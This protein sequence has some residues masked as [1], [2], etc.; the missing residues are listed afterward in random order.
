MKRILYCGYY[1]KNTKYNDLIRD[2]NRIKKEKDIPYRSLFLDM[3]LCTFKYKASFHDY[4]MFKFYEKN[5]KQKKGYLCTGELYEFYSMMND[6]SEIYNFTNKA[7]FN[8]VFRRFIKRDFI[9]LEENTLEDFINWIADKTYIIAKPN[10]GV[11]GKGIEKIC[12]SEYSNIGELYKHLKMNNLNLIEDFIQ[13]HNDI[14][15]V[16]PS[17]VNTIRIVTVRQNKQTDII[18][19]VLR[20]GIGNHIDN[21]SA[22]GIAAPIDIKTGRVYKPAVSKRSEEIYEY[23]PRTK[24]KINGLKIP[25]WNETIKMVIELS[26]I[27]PEVKTV[28]WDIAITEY[29]PELIEGNNNW[30][31]DSFQL[32]YDEGRKHL[33]NKYIQK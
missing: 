24:T 13:Q 2:F 8:E 5:E 4:F 12:I 19:A 21:F 20:I 23:H 16:N 10:D 9:F 30:N 6:K 18:A 33:L 29:G 25:Y 15:T 7:K 28:G 26:K 31:K 1:I 22:G 11:A 32:P 27:I 17:S 3:L 14:N